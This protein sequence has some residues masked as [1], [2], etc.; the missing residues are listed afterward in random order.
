V[1]TQQLC[2][3]ADG[4]GRLA[5]FEVVPGSPELGQLVRERRWDLLPELFTA[6][7]AAGALSQRDAIAELVRRG[8]VTA[9]AA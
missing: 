1:I 3:R 7:R 4:A 2:D 5:A 9:P 6:Q 8:Y